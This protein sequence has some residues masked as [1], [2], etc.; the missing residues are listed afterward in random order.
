MIHLPRTNV[1]EAAIIE[2]TDTH[3]EKRNW[4]LVSPVNDMW[5]FDT[6]EELVDFLN[7]GKDV[8]ACH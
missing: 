1:N 6:R 7:K 2:F 4:L 3:A 8:E 5:S